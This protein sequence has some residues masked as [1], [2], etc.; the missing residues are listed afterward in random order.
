MKK[1]QHLY[2][3]TET[4]NNFNANRNLSL[5]FVKYSES[6]ER[7]FKRHVEIVYLETLHYFYDNDILFQPITLMNKGCF[8]EMYT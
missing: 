7:L 8:V 6:I 4:I 1:N 2:K 5:V 3:I